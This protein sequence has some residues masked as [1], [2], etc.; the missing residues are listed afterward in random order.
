MDAGATD[1]GKSQCR[2]EGIGRRIGRIAVDLAHHELAVPGDALIEQ[3][4]IEGARVTAA[5]RGLCDHDAVDIDETRVVL[6]E[7]LIV[8]AV[9]R[10]SIIERD[11]ERFDVADAAG[12]ERLR[13]QRR[14]TTGVERRQLDRVRVVQRQHGR[15]IGWLERAGNE[16]R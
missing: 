5:A 9:V 2:M 10:R 3:I 1:L 12:M 11:Q 14:Q 15:L 4:G 16:A 13:Q 7:P 6:L 8:R